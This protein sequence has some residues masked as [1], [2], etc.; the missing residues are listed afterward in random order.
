MGYFTAN[1]GL[2]A[3][4]EDS[5]FR[6]IVGADP[7]PGRLAK[8]RD[9]AVGIV[10]PM[11]A[12]EAMA[13]RE[14]IPESWLSGSPERFFYRPEDVPLLVPSVT[15]FVTEVKMALD[16]DGVHTVARAVVRAGLVDP[17]DFAAMRRLTYCRDVALRSEGDYAVTFEILAREGEF[18]SGQAIQIEPHVRF[19]VNGRGVSI[20]RPERCEALPETVLDVVTAATRAPEIEAVERLR[21]ELRTAAGREVA[22]ARFW[23][24]DSTPPREARPA[25]DLDDASRLV[26]DAAS[27]LIEGHIPR[28]RELGQSPLFEA[29]VPPL[30]DILR[31]GFRYDL[32]DDLLTVNSTRLA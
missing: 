20:T 6:G 2:R 8:A 23:F 5:V 18:Q 32:D 31:Q 30:W 10:D 14:L 28:L 7:D 21:R 3:D 15:G 19:T 16:A 13:V 11:E 27:A 4:F 17:E 1:P 29:V 9:A 12:M 26:Q 24:P 25:S 22:P